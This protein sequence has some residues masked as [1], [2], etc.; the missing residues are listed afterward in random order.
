VRSLVWQVRG[1]GIQIA[2]KLRQIALP[3]QLPNRHVLTGMIPI[4]VDDALE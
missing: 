3:E 2:D 1:L 4:V